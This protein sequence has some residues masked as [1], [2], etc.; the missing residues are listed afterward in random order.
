MSLDQVKKRIWFYEFDLPDGTRT[1]TDIPA[2][3]RPIHTSRRDKLA[4]VIRECVQNPDSLTAADLASH[5]GYYSVELSRHFRFVRGY[6]VRDESLMAARLIAQALGVSNVEYIKADLQKL[7]LEPSMMADFVLVYG[8][9]YHL[10]NPIHAIRLA[11]QM[12]RKHILI[13]TQ[14]LGYDISGMVEDG[15]YMGLRKVEGIFGLV[16]DYSQRREGGSTDFALVPS[17]NSVLYLLKI[18]GFTEIS[19]LP[20]SPN[21]YEQFYRQRRVIVYGCKS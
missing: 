12:C 16:A 19:V 7:K 3:I 11:S 1:L 5:E 21:D 10:E 9:I 6:E 17:L 4:Q 15:H 20:S 18:F 14:V 13:E 8:L 2:H